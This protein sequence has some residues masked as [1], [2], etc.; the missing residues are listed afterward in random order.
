MERKLKFELVPDSCWYSNI[1]TILP[2]KVWE[3]IKKDVKSR[4]NGRCEI[5][6]KQTS[7]L[8]AHE[9]WSYDVKSATQKLENVIAVCKDCHAAIH[10]GRTSL[11]GNAE[12]AEDHY[13][14]VNGC[15]Y[16][17]MRA[18]LNKA[19]EEHKKRNLIPEWKLDVSF[20]AEKYKDVKI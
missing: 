4:A 13:M 9:V 6:G 10:I 18:D 14:K 12:R 2:K 19:N 20:L 16:T 7:L 8:D 5:C 3:Y 15:T 17:E 1:R 11:V